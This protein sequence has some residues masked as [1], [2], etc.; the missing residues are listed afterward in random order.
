MSAAANLLFLRSLTE[1][2]MM[3]T[4]I[5]VPNATRNLLQK[6][7]VNPFKLL[8]TTANFWF[9]EATSR[10]S[11]NCHCF[12]ILLIFWMFPVLRGILDTFPVHVD[13]ATVIFVQNLDKHIK[14][15]LELF[16]CGLLHPS[17]EVLK[18]YLEFCWYLLEQLVRRLGVF[19]VYFL[20]NE[21]QY[22]ENYCVGG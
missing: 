10:A 19:L 7:Q 1:L 21:L 8:S 3:L 15:D 17:S 4:S 20:C 22:L 2:A 13:D 18:S 14:I 11:Y 16:F 9:F 12:L 5:N 6:C